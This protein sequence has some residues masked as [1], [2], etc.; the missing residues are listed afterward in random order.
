MSWLQNDMMTLEVQSQTFWGNMRNDLAQT[1]ADIKNTPAFLGETFQAIWGYFDQFAWYVAGKI[2]WL[3][4]AVFGYFTKKIEWIV[5]TVKKAWDSVKSFMWKAWDVASSVVSTV[6]WKRAL[7]W[8]VQAW[9]TY[10][11]WERGPETFTPATSGSI[12]NTT[13]NKQSTINV[14]M[15]GVS[16][17]NDQDI[18]TL[19]D[20][21]TAAIKRDAQLYNMWIN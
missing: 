3:W 14:N 2:Q 6:T 16:V 7:W 1:F 12:N 15:W 5:W 17:R 20:T 13:E 18:K 9:K 10:L 11:V 4:D 21:I 8:P 19:T